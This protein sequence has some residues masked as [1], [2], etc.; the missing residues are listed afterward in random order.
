MRKAELKEAAETPVMGP[1][2]YSDVVKK[3]LKL[4]APMPI[5]DIFEAW[6]DHLQQ[7]SILR[8]SQRNLTT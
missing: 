6:R 2:L 3:N 1:M 4:A 8:V 7:V 5:E